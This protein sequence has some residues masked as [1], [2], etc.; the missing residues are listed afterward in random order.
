MFNFNYPRK[1]EGE[2]ER[3]KRGGGGGER[4]RG[5]VRHLTVFIFYIKKIYSY[6]L[7][8]SH[9]IKIE[10]PEFKIVN[11]SVMTRLSREDMSISRVAGH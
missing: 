4:G 7:I 11:Q 2:E 3:E 9:G 6:S 1:R 10:N 5:R 8:G